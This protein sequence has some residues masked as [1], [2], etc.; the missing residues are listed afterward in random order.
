MFEQHRSRDL[1]YSLSGRVVMWMAAFLLLLYS[2]RANTMLL[3]NEWRRLTSKL[4]RARS[5]LSTCGS[6]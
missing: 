4:W 1:M 3:Y 5:A 6:N 2:L